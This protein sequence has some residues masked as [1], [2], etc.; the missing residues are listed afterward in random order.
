VEQGARPRHDLIR[1][2]LAALAL[3][4]GLAQPRLASG[5]RPALDPTRAR[6]EELERL[7]VGTVSAETLPRLLPALKDP[8]AELR[9]AAVALLARPALEPAKVHPLLLKALA[10]REPRVRAIAVHAIGER[11]KAALPLAPALARLLGEEKLGGLIA[12]TAAQALLKLGPETA[13]ALLAVLPA[14]KRGGRARLLAVLAQV[15]PA[16]ALPVLLAEKKRE[17]IEAAARGL[18][19]TP[20]ISAELVKVLGD[21]GARTTARGHAAFLL[22]R[23]GPPA[24]AVAA[25]RTAAGAPDL[26]LALAAEEALLLGR[27]LT[28][29]PQRALAALQSSKAVLRARAAAVLALVRLADRPLVAALVPLTEDRSKAVREAAFR[30]LRERWSL[31]T[32]EER[33]RVTE[34]RVRTA[35]SPY[36]DLLDWPPTAAVLPRLLEVASRERD[37]GE[38]FARVMALGHEAVPAITPALKHSSVL[39]RRTALDALARLGPAAVGAVPELVAA[40]HDADPRVKLLA[41][42]VLG[43]VGPPAAGAGPPLVSALAEKGVLGDAVVAALGDLG[44]AALPALIAGLKDPREPLR[45]R[46]A[47]LLGELG[48]SAATAAEALATLATARGNARPA[49]LAALT[50]VAPRDA[51]TARAVLEGLRDR[52]P[53]VRSAAARGAAACTA[54]PELVSALIAALGD[55]GEDVRGGAARSLGRLGTSARSAVPALLKRGTDPVEAVRLE[56]VRALASL[57]RARAVPV[58]IERLRD[59]SDEVVVAALALLAAAGPAARE[60]GPALGKLLA[61]AAGQPGCARLPEAARALWRVAATPPPILAA[62]RRSLRVEW[63]DDRDPELDCPVAGLRALQG[64][65]AAAVPAIGALLDYLVAME[66]EARRSEATS[67][68]AVVDG[69]RAAVRVVFA[70]M[71]EAALPT[72]AAAAASKRSAPTRLTVLEALAA[73]GRSTPEVRAALKVAAGDRDKTLRDVARKLQQKLAG[74]R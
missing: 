53:E 10:D 3:V 6:V 31:L 18:G 17:S 72:L 2:G 69:A 74:G 63:A 19:R 33:A 22:G 37:R 26:E 7:G 20:E 24:A 21:E 50:L 65:G 61:R 42:W 68:Q 15:A 25:L 49:A 58:L 1:L 11:G 14:T 35:G 40:L 45:V 44:A 38:L 30:L 16:Q 46:C 28:G 48:S 32:R 59:S 56:A 51:R 27:T 70:G 4:A 34:R 67:A 13:P 36:R 71:G 41:V 47:S 43:R 55:K 12:E 39:V 54:S 52:S 23:L 8:S 73:I 64:L 57:D 5:E 66:K 9:S 29:A 62:A 60:A